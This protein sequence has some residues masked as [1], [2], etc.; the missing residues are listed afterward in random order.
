MDIILKI[1]ADLHKFFN[2]NSYTYNHTLRVFNS[3]SKHYIN[4]EDCIV[5]KLKIIAL[6]HDVIED[7][8][9]TIEMLKEM[10]YNDFIWVLS[11]TSIIEIFDALN[12]ITRKTN[13]TYIDYINNIKQNKLATIVK[14]LDLEDNL[15]NCFI[16]H[17]SSLTNRYIK[18]LTILTK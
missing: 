2:V 6:L 8:D 15:F 10:Y 1:K 4:N 18:A 13:E 17:N 11:Y 9:Y 16:E 14:V 12:V 7:T 5:T 3:I